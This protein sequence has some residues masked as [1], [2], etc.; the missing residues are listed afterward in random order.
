[1][2]AP[3]HARTLSQLEARTLLEPLG[4][5]QELDRLLNFGLVAWAEELA[6]RGFSLTHALHLRGS[7]MSLDVCVSRPPFRY[8]VEVRLDSIESVFV[9]RERLH[10]H[11]ALSASGLM[12][13]LRERTEAQINLLMSAKDAPATRPSRETM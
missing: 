2:L 8:E 9:L 10:S 6:Q 4:R 11:H 1:M 12:R 3:R 13:I 5:T 7:T